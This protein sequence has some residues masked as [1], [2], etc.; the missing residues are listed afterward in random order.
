MSPRAW[1]ERAAAETA[2]VLPLVHSPAARAKLV[3]A[4]LL[5]V[6]M[7]AGQK[8][9]CACAETAAK[10]TIEPK[11]TDFHVGATTRRETARMPQSPYACHQDGLMG[12][13]RRLDCIIKTTQSR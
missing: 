10:L 7:V 8:I 4:P 9:V 6:L 12:S 5:L 11:K 13:S 2:P 3:A 1:L